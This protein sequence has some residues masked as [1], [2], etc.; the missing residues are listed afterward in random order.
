MNRSTQK[1]NRER[2]RNK[3]LASVGYKIEKN[4]RNRAQ[5]GTITAVEAVEDPNVLILRRE[6]EELG[7]GRDTME[8]G[9]ERSM[10]ANFK[11]VLSKT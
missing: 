7:L 4:E 9:V 3:G 11:D 6:F 10:A 8:T 2:T 5:S 1:R